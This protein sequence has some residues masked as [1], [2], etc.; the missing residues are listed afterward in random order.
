M[1]HILDGILTAEFS[2]RDFLKGTV[3]AT[4]AVAGL[5]LLPRENA[6]AEGTMAAAEHPA[7][8]DMEEG[9][10]WIGA[11]CWHNCGGRCVN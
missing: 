1:A 5:G 8:V 11:A 2:R 4:A 6:M 3:A 10:K 9:G 7:I